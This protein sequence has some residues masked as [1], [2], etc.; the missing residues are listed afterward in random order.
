[1][2][3]MKVSGLLNDAQYNSRPM[4]VRS[5]SANVS[6]EEVAGFY[7]RRWED[8]FS[9]SR[10]GPWQQIGTLADECFFTVQYGEAGGNAFGRLLISVVPSGESNAP[11]G[12]GVVKPS[13]GVVVSD[14]L[15][16]DGPKEGR[17]TVISSEQTVSEVA[18]F[19]QTEMT[20]DGWGL[21]QH[22]A[23]RGGVVLVFRKGTDENNIVIM[24]AGD[25]TQILVN[26]VE[27]N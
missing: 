16:N 23:E 14:L 25:A 19:Y 13:D 11:L 20:V 24:P 27:I 26:E 15:T 7:R 8:A 18:S 21:D 10:F 1:M 17:V 4:T 22:F 5:F 9:E 12:Q 2:S 6:G 3:E